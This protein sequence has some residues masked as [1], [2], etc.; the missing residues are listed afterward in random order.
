ME[1]WLFYGLIAAIFIAI[2]DT[3]SN[4]LINRYEYIEYILY[5]NFIVFICTILYIYFFN[6]SFKNFKIPDKKDIFI[7]FLRILIIYLIIEP[8]IF[9]SLKY[10][11]NPSYAKSIINLNT[12]FLFLLSMYFLKI[13]LNSLKLLGI[14]L[15]F[16]GSYCIQK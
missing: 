4:D 16:L 10:C 9:Y 2:R 13:K 11:D 14:L 7:I 6:V 5:A 1:Q 12:L 8:S 15:I 3:F